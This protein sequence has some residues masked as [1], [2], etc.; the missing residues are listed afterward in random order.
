MDAVQPGVAP[1]VDH[2]TEPFSLLRKNKLMVGAVAIISTLVVIQVLFGRPPSTDALVAPVAPP[3]TTAQTPPEAFDGLRKAIHQMTASSQAEAATLLPPTADPR[4]PRAGFGGGG[5][6][7]KPTEDPMAADLKRRQYEARFGSNVVPPHGAPAQASASSP[8]RAIGA[9]PVEDDAGAPSR[10]NLDAIAQAVTRAMGATPGAAPRAEPATQPSRSTDASDPNRPLFRPTAAAGLHRVSPGTTI[11][12]TL[13]NRLV[14][15]GPLDC[16]VSVDVYSHDLTKVIPKGSK[17]I[18]EATPVQTTG[19]SRLA[20]TFS[21]IVFPD[22][23]ELGINNLIGMNQLGDQGLKDQ[24]N[25]HYAASFSAA[26]A[27]GLI[28]G[29]AQFVGTGFSRE[30]SGVTVI[31]GDVGN[32]TSQATSQAMNRFLN[33]L[34]TITIREGHRVRVYLRT[35]LDLPAWGDTP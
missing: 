26:G 28:T 31:A 7:A 30:R 17:V 8:Y 4:E 35:H 21:T 34:P 3:E 24:V 22:G 16:L 23:T 11:E 5:E 32:S 27:V 29:F 12:T 10:P 20:V 33:R 19:E 9:Q 18:G 2:R 6:A 1:I 13:E 25:N 15:G 14:I